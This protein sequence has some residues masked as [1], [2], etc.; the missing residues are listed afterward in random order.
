MSFE[1]SIKALGSLK[2][3][4][5]APSLLLTKCWYLASYGSFAYKY[6]LS[7]SGYFSIKFNNTFVFPVPEPP[8]VNILY[9]WLGLSGQFFLCLVFV[10]VNVIIKVDRLYIAIS[11]FKHVFYLA[12]H[13]HIL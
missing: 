1:H 8:I 7:M 5:P 3:F 4:M 11:V 2:W 9:G 13:F 6:I 12:F 10:F